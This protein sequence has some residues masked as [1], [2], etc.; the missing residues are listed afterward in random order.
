VYGMALFSVIIFR[1]KASHNLTGDGY[2]GISL[3]VMG[4]FSIIEIITRIENGIR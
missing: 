1:I 4:C 2:H 3:A